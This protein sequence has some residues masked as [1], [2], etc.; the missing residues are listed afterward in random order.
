[1]VFLLKKMNLA[2]V[3]EWKEAKKEIIACHLRRQMSRNAIID[4]S[5]K[6]AMSEAELHVLKARLQGGIRNK[7]QRGELK[8]PLP[9]G[10]VYDEQDRVVLDPDRQVQQAIRCFFD[11]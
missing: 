9:V 11:A 7:A 2:V 5:L 8:I 6:G 10:L 3:L 1:M 4:K